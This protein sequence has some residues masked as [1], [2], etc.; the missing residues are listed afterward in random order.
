MGSPS[1]RQG[2]RE[3]ARRGPP[4]PAPDLPATHPAALLVTLVAA[5]CVLVSVSYQLSD[6][7]AWQNLA[8][9]KAIWTLHA[10]PH[11]QVFAWPNFGEPLVNPSWGFTALIWPIWSAG[12]VA[13]LFVWR[14]ATT[15]V[16]FA[17]LWLTARRLGARGFTVWLV[18]VACALVYRQRSQVRPE[19]LASVWLALTIWILETRR[20]GGP[21]RSAWLVPI[22]CAWANSHLSYYLGFLVLGIHAVGAVLSGRS[23]GAGGAR[24]LAWIGLAMAA[25]VFVN[26]Y[27]W[28]AVA[29]PF[30]FLLF[31]RH[32][33]IWTVISELKPIDWKLNLANGLP[34]IVAGWPLLVLWR[35]RRS[36][37]D[38]VELMTCV[39]FT[40]LG[41]SSSRFIASYALAAAPYFGRDLDEF[42]R[43]WRA[44]GR[45]LPVWPRAALASL[46]CVVLGWGEWTRHEGPIG[47]AFD[48]RRTADAAC[49]F[50]AAHGVRG[51]GFN[52]F[53]VGGTMLWHFWPDRQRL[54]FMTGSPEDSP[55][56][57][58]D[59]YMRGLSTAEG[60]RALDDR[61]RFDYA[62]LS[63]Y[64]AWSYTLLDLLDADPAWARVFIDDV[65]ALYVRRAGPLA[66]VADS[67]GYRALMG[68]RTRTTEI[69]RR[70]AADSILRAVLADELKRQARETSMNFYGRQMMRAL[71]PV[72]VPGGP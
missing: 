60:W 28:H 67:F 47:I 55:R 13:G 21:D 71:G 31:W 52:H 35:W 20:Q 66:A 51:R 11:R 44:P 1:R 68:G 3:R 25:A 54:P 58:R 10:I 17:L 39:F 63:R 57:I 18:I 29:R 61:F 70:A 46:A 72:A 48:R 6:P 2:R 45:S 53:Y 38:F 9:G 43:T 30:Q 19:T 5:A 22:A 33:P 32:E 50:M 62:L 56:E 41:L 8:F 59:L 34:V 27:G 23:P 7:D 36:G 15:L 37:I 12:D 40:A 65:A 49:E 14:W 26:P 42:V 4:V 24:R 69:L 16:T 64:Y